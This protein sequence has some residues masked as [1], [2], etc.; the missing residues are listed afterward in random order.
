MKILAFARHPGEPLHH[1][2]RLDIIADSA[3][4][5]YNKPV[6]L[7]DFTPHWTADIYPAYRV[8]RLGKGITPKFAPRYYDAVTLAMRL[9]PSH[10]IQE[11]QQGHHPGGV[12]SLFDN[13]L[14]VGQWIP[15]DPTNSPTLA[16]KAPGIDTTLTHNQ[17]AI[18]PILSEISHIATIK[19]GDIL[20][21]CRIPM[22]ANLTPG[23]DI[24]ITLNN[25][26]VLP[27]RLR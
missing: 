5:T 27:I 23:I 11:L 22:A 17:T 10:T 21:P 4:V 18:E 1:P 2:L 9:I 16:I 8:S 6:F 3:I 14:A 20:M 19:T 24:T 15:I 7:P 25:L 26:P 13:C 12:T